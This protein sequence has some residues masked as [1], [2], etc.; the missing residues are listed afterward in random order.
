[1]KNLFTVLLF[2]AITVQAQTIG[3]PIT[4]LPPLPQ[5]PLSFCGQY[6]NADVCK[7]K[8]EETK[9][10]DGYTYKKGTDPNGR[11]VW[12]QLFWPNGQPRECKICMLP[13]GCDKKE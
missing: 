6:P 8:K 5:Y 7:S 10:I 3:P 1:M 4:V 2:S 12:I 9:C 11:V 13:E